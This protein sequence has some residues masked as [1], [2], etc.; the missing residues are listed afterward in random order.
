MIDKGYIGKVKAG[1][2]CFLFSTI[3]SISAKSQCSSIYVTVDTNQACVPG[4]FEFVVHGYPAGAS[5]EWDFG[6][7]SVIQKDTYNLIQNTAA[8]ISLTLTV[9]LKSGAKCVK[10]YANI[11]KVHAKPD[12]Q[13]QL[14]KSVLCSTNDS[15]TLTDKTP[16][17]VYRIWTIEGSNHGTSKSKFSTQFTS[18][19]KKDLYLMVE[20]SFGCRAVKSF[21]EVVE[22]MPDPNLDLSGLNLKA[23]INTPVS[24]SQNSSIN[25]TDIKSIL[26]SFAGGLPATSTSFSPKNIMYQKGGKYNVN[27]EIETKKGCKYSFQKTQF[28]EAI[29][30]LILDVSLTDSKVCLPL[31]LAITIKNGSLDSEITWDVSGYEICLDSSLHRTRIYHYEKAGK[32]PVNITYKDKYCVSHYTHIIDAHRVDAKLY[33]NQHVDCKVPF[34]VKLINQSTSSDPGKISYLWTIRDSAGKFV[35]AANTTDFSFLIKDWGTYSVEL[36]ASQVNGCKDVQFQKEFIRALPM[37]I[38]FFALPMHVCLNQE[39]EMV[40]QTLKSSYRSDDYFLWYL[41]KN[42]DTSIMDSSRLFTPSFIASYDGKYD[43]LV[44]GWNSVGCT[45]ELFVPE[46]FEVIH[47]TADFRVSED[48][49]CTNN[50]FELKSFVNPGNAIYTHGWTAYNQTEDTF[51][52]GDYA[53][54]S[55]TWIDK[56]G[57]YDIRYDIS[58]KE[59]CRDTA[60]KSA[61]LIVSDIKAEIDLPDTQTCRGVPFVPVA[62]TINYVYGNASKAE[63]YSW[64]IT[65]DSGFV[66]DD[67]SKKAPTIKFNRNGEYVLRLI[68]RNDHDCDDTAWSDTIHVGLHPQFKFHDSIVCAKT[69]FRFINNTDKFANKWFYNLS[70]NNSHFLSSLYKDSGTLVINKNGE[71]TLLLIASRDSLCFDTSTISLQVVSP[72][73]DFYALDSNLYCAPVYERFRSTSLYADTLFWDFGDGKRLKT[74]NPKVTTVYTENSGDLF[75]YT[76]SLIAKNK[77]GCADTMIKK[78]MIT[79][80]GPV[81][82]FTVENIRGC[83]PLVVGLKGRT[84][85][86]S[87]MYIDYGDGSDFGFNFN[88]KH[89]YKNHWRI[90]ENQY[91]PIILVVDKNGCQNA[92]KSDSTIW[93]KPTPTAYIG[94]DDSVACGQ[95]KME[96]IYLGREASS[97][98]WDFDGN[99]TPDSTTAYGKYLYQTPGKYNLT[100]INKNKFGCSDTATKLIHVVKAPA[101]QIGVDSFGCLTKL[102]DV[103]DLSVVDTGVASRLWTIDYFGKISTRPDSSFSIQADYLGDILL[104]LEIADRAGCYSSDSLTIKVV[105]AKN[106][107]PAEIEVVTVELDGSASIKVA[108]AVASYEKSELH[109]QNALGGFDLLT[110]SDVVLKFEKDLFAQTSL[111]PQCYKVRHLDSCGFESAFSETHCTIFLEVT[112]NENGVNDLKWTPYNWPNT[113]FYYIILRKSSTGFDT[114][115]VVSASVNQYRDSL[116]CNE[117]YCYAILSVNNSFKRL[118][119]SNEACQ[120]PVYMGNQSLTNV[121]N[122]TV[123]DDSYIRIELQ[124]DKPNETHKLSKTNELG[125]INQINIQNNSYDDYQVDVQNHSYT[126]S[127]INIDHCLSEGKAGLVGK[128]ILFSLEKIEDQLYFNWT[129]YKQWP[130][131]VLEY[132]IQR[133][134][135]EN[136]VPFKVVSAADTFVN[137][138]ISSD[139]NASNCFRIVAIGDSSESHSNTQC[140]K[141]KPIVFIP[142]A[143]APNGDLINDGFKPVALFIKS[144]QEYE[145]GIYE[146]TIFNRWGEL[147]FSSSDPEEYWDGSINGQPGAMGTYFYQFKVRGLDDS[148]QSFFGTITLVR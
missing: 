108:P 21:F 66:I 120:T 103:A 33:S 135:A 22:V 35:T 124:S 17:S 91:K 76:V 37:E 100:L 16:L 90:I 106:Q 25:N 9:H 18:V 75:P 45:D 128:S 97:W 49:V 41:Y 56:P 85:N 133:K 40:N 94:V 130:T 46:A 39:T 102:L 115:R 72:V 60:I 141:A 148:I 61:V 113:D 6:N 123:V 58:I 71:Y 111:S 121:K 78:N 14:S 101:I 77:T 3:F 19:G 136:F 34:E 112:S 84:E 81:V 26:W 119:R 98:F 118:S 127:A 31:D 92:V 50:F 80:K 139:L 32:Y 55:S 29:D 48:T 68:A 122:V 142:N 51:T 4:I 70:P 30:T 88:E 54:L 5:F 38:N 13:I 2:L 8:N 62:K 134:V 1:F 129:H 107:Q 125:G 10:T 109:K 69:P 57:V 146:F 74:D 89:T 104:K 53:Y 59:L 24:F 147:I 36:E 42:G 23:C 20:D 137:I 93:V 140:L 95:L 131:A 65:P 144:P 27:L 12:P 64:K 96:Y 28:V 114:L 44:K 11:A 47:P 7:G 79:V 63:Y 117:N 138:P 116:L 82:D 43:V 73:A 105:D 15:I 86:V 52:F 132:Q 145:N 143:F 126:Y 110:T 99:G 83:E 87:K 67:K